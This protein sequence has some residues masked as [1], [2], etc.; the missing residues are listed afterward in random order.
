MF[1]IDKLLHG[2]LVCTIFI[3]HLLWK[4]NLSQLVHKNRTHSPTMLYILL[5]K[6]PN[7][8]TL[9]VPRDDVTCRG[10]ACPVP[11]FQAAAVVLNLS[12]ATSRESYTHR[13]KAMIYIYHVNV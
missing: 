3:M 12:H 9:F 2:W 7:K 6:L 10:V 5:L 1:G 11:G 13:L 4:S 8:K